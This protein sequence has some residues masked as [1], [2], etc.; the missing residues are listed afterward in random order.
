M[1]FA[2]VV[3]VLV[4]FFGI[5]LVSTKAQ[6]VVATWT[7]GSGDWNNAANWSTGTV[8]N[9]PGFAS[10]PAICYSVMINTSNSAISLDGAAIDNL[11]LGATNSLNVDGGLSL[12]NGASFN[13]GTIVSGGLELVIEANGTSLTNYGSINVSN[14]IGLTGYGGALALLTN[15]GA[16][17]NDGSM[18][19][20]QTAEVSNFGTFTNGADGRIFFGNQAFFSNYGTFNNFGEMQGTFDGILLNMGTFN[21]SGSLDLLNTYGGFGGT[22]TLE[23]DGTLNNTGSLGVG[24]GGFINTGTLNNFGVLGTSTSDPLVG[25]SNTGVVNNSGSFTGEGPLG[26]SGVL[27]NSGTLTIL[28][29]AIS[30]SSGNPIASVLGNG[31]ALNNSGN[32]VTASGTAFDNSGTFANSGTVTNEG[33]FT[34][35]GVVLVTNTGLFTTSTNYIQ[36]AGSTFVN[37]TLT[38]TGGAIVDIQGGIL[39]GT[40]T[41]NGNTFVAG[42]MMPGDAPGT[43]TIV[44]NYEQASTGIFYEQMSPYSH[45]FLDVSGNV[46]LDPGAWLEISLLD[47]FNPLGLTFS[48]MDFASL[49][50]QF[51]NG[52]SF[53]D[54]NYLWDITYRQHEIDITAV[55]AAE[56][57]SLLLLALGCLVVAAFAKRKTVAQ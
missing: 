52:S 27:N 47:G 10:C 56:P 31:G 19:A 35:S 43:L 32:I 12:V 20:E 45:A 8:P 37:G 4:L 40:G 6:Q 11:T 33:T 7:D 30:N 5:Q 28:A 14:G 38:T 44:G 2:R 22:N 9:N 25:F 26:N 29:G 39:G 51:A 50:G 34:N 42:T 54:D 24:A 18:T 1:R 49:S 36:T 55:R 57:G 3:A 21:N 41:I 16:V 53:W 17:T 23:N 15:Y 13:Y 48:V 46:I